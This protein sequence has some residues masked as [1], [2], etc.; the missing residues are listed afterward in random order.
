MQLIS[1]NTA[2][3]TGNCPDQV[4]ALPDQKPDVIAL[5]EVLSEG[6]CRFREQLERCH[7]E[8]KHVV[9]SFELAQDLD[10]LRGRRRYGELIASRWALIPMPPAD[11]PP[12]DRKSPVRDHLDT[13]GRYRTAHDTYSARQR[14]RAEMEEGRDARGYL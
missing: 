10:L 7:A 13:V 8:L 3:R 4:K 14:Q 1:W 6:R 5:Q 11:F 12:L 2:S 9:D